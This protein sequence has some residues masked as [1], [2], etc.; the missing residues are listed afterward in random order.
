MLLICNAV[1]LS[2]ISFCVRVFMSWISITT[3]EEAENVNTLL[4]QLL[5]AKREIY[6]FPRN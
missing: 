1:T 3:R 2:H 6:E 4:I 5:T